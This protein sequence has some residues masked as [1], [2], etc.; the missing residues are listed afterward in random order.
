MVTSG[1][2]L[3]LFRRREFITLLGGAAAVA[4]RGARTKDG[5]DTYCAF[6]TSG[7]LDSDK[8]TGQNIVELQS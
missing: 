8:L 1:I 7:H 2:R 6:F 3:R 5:V 4:V